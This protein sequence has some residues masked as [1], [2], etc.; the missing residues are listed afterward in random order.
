[1]NVR[2]TRITAKV[3]FSNSLF[4]DGRRRVS[5]DAAGAIM[6]ERYAWQFKSASIEDGAVLTSVKLPDMTVKMSFPD[7]DNLMRL[8]APGTGSKVMPSEEKNTFV[9]SDDQNST[10]FYFGEWLDGWYYLPHGYRR[11]GDP[12]LADFGPF[13]SRTHAQLSAVGQAHAWYDCPQIPKEMFR[14]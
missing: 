9:V 3:E 8:A 1:M 10:V 2:A 11:Y 7:W 4:C 5:V 13:P 12:D 6:I 14:R